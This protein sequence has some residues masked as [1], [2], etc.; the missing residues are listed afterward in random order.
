MLEERIRAIITH[1][2]YHSMQSMWRHLELA[3]Q[4]AAGKRLKCPKCA[5]RFV[6]SE[7][8]ASSLSGLPG[9]ADAANTTSF[10]LEKRP[11]SRDD[12]PIADIRGRLARHF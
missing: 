12:L 2:P 1:A 10:D 9:Q 4:V 3:D 7:E 8:D 5:T 11:P 6:V